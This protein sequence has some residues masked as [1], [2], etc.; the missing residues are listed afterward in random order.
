MGEEKI[1]N[2]DAQMMSWEDAREKLAALQKASRPPQKTVTIQKWLE[3]WTTIY[4]RLISS[5]NNNSI[6]QQNNGEAKNGK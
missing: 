6:T 2:G 1:T 4:H 5:E 3:D